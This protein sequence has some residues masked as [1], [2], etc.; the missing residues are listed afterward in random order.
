MESIEVDIYDPHVVKEIGEKTNKCIVFEELPK[1]NKYQGMI[2]AVKHNEFKV[3]SE[4][5]WKEI[6]D[7]NNVVADLKG[8]LPRSL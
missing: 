7:R 5:E 2:G 6:L 1:S 8:F 4:L 3:I